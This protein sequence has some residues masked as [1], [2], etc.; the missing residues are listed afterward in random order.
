[1]ASR[2]YFDNAA[3]TP[4]APE[5]IEVMHLHMTQQYGNPSSIHLQGRS[6]RNCVEIS[7]KTVAGCLGASIGE[8]FFT[9]GGTEANNMVIKCAVRD[10]GIRRIISS[11]IEHP[12]V[13]KSL[14]RMHATTG[15]QVEHLPIDDLGRP[16]MDALAERL[17]EG[18]L[19]TL[20]S[21]MHANN[22]IGTMIDLHHVGTICRAHGAL[23]H[24]DTVQ[25][26]GHFTFNLNETPIDFI[27]GS[28]HK[29]HGPKGTGFIY[30]RQGLAIG[31]LIEGGGQERNLRAGTENIAG[32]AGLAEAISAANGRMKSGEDLVGSIKAYAKNQLAAEFEGLTFN[33][34]LTGPNLCS[35]LSVNFPKSSLAD[36]LTF[37]LDIE[38]ISASGGSACASGAEQRSHVMAVIKPGYEGTTI[39]FSFSHLNSFEQVDVLTDTLHKIL[40]TTI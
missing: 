15:V 35:V 10:L 30:I 11:P 5:V 16:D 6:A 28:A 17:Q 39:R 4:M 13:L 31:A 33:G 2:I 22:E 27:T 29:F 8:I 3:S 32:I 37:N 20:V 23:F 9:S 1:M 24:S 40:R 18:D 36:L 12:C 38:G 34:D 21:L 14:V 25:T 19:K 26:I 7:R